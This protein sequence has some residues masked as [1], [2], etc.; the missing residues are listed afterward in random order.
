MLR[1]G[2]EMLVP[3]AE[4]KVGTT[5]VVRPGEKVAT[6]GVVVEGESALDQS[7]LTGESLPIEVA[8]AATFLV[9]PS[10]PTAA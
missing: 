8:A 1:D 4:L 3:I 10:T 5:F 7:M 2:V 6:D 9:R